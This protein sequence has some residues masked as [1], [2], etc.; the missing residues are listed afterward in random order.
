MALLYMHLY[1]SVT[2]QHKAQYD[3]RKCAKVLLTCIA[4][5]MT[6]HATAA[7]WSVVPYVGLSVLQDQSAEIIGFD[8]D[9]NGRADV[10]IEDGFTSGLSLRYHYPETS[11]ISELGWEYRSNDSYITTASGTRLP[12]GNYASNIFYLNARYRFVTGSQILPW[13]GGGVVWTQEVDLD[14]ESTAGER[15]FSDSGSIGFQVLAGADYDL[16]ERLYLTGELRYSHQSDLDLKEEAGGSASIIGID[17]Q[18]VNRRLHSQQLVQQ[19][20]PICCFD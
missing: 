3:F 10:A 14:S 4:T 11:W 16:T 15:S 7:N 5:T 17:Y 13:V 12:G 6:S 19:P 20:R 18:P 9:S 2:T 8:T 1:Q